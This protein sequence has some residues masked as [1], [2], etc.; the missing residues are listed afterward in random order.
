MIVEPLS[1]SGYGEVAYGCFG[2]ANGRNK[3]QL[4]YCEPTNSLDSMGTGSCVTGGAGGRGLWLK[5]VELGF[6]T[7][8]ESVKL[9]LDYR[10][11]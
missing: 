7:V 9:I 4:V 11:A 6:E 5:Q 10:C 1:Q 2:I 3:I 8:M